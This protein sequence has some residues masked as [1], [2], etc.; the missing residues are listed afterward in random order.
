MRFWRRT[1]GTEF[2]EGAR[3]LWGAVESN[4][5]DLADRIG[6]NSG[7]L[8]KL[9]YGDRRPSIELAVRIQDILGIPAV[10][11]ARPPTTSFVPPAARAA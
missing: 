9:I 7:Q 11:W 2:S 8:A 5:E 1:L 6:I 4:L 10:E 3:L